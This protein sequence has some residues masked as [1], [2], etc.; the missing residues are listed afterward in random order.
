MKSHQMLIKSAFGGFFLFKMML[1]RKK[2]AKPRLTLS[3]KHNIVQVIYPTQ[4]YSFRFLGG[5]SYEDLIF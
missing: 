1:S 4:H 2:L 3:A 5:C